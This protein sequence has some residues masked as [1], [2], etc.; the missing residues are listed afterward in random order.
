MLLTKAVS[1]PASTNKLKKEKEK[2][3]QPKPGLALDVGRWHH[4]R[5]A[6]SVGE[7]DLS[8]GSSICA[9]EVRSSTMVEPSIVGVAHRPHG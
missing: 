8:H 9:E 7:L 5:G 2:S 3:T 6:R 1:L 4:R